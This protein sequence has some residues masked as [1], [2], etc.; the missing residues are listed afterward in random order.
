MRNTRPNATLR[1]FGYPRT[2]LHE[3][4][5]WAVLVRPAQPTLGSLVL[6]ALE[7]E[8]SYGD[9]PP[10][11][12]IEQGELV[13]K[14]EQMLRS[15]C[16]FERIN[17]LMLMMVDP[18]VHFHVLPRYS[19]ERQFGGDDFVDKG[20]PAIP[21]LATTRHASEAIIEALRVSWHS[22]QEEGRS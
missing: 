19:G 11:A 20:W 6:C 15:F 18:H 3:G 7:E 17:Y 2:L 9:L 14:I 13:A 1:K 16:N 8:T 12:Y 10:Q 21:D 4:R 22:D 5:H